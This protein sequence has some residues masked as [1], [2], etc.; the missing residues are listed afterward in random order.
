M[1]G[2]PSLIDWSITSN[3]VY[4]I[5]HT[6]YV[7]IKYVLIYRG[8]FQCNILHLYTV[9]Y[10][11]RSVHLSQLRFPVVIISLIVNE[12]V[13]TCQKQFCKH[14]VTMKSCAYVPT[15]SIQNCFWHILTVVLFHKS[16]HKCFDKSGPLLQMRSHIY[17]NTARYIHL[18][19]VIYKQRSVHLS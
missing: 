19:T 2:V 14:K 8:W 9:I 12:Y 4:V 16:G 17:S 15:V 13:K 10:N 11:Q 18:C 7:L 6:I 5:I 1:V 3:K